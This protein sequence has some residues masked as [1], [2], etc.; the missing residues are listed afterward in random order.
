MTDT[1]P[2]YKDT[3]TDLRSEFDRGRMIQKSIPTMAR[4]E[5]CQFLLFKLQQHFSMQEDVDLVTLFN[6]GVRTGFKT[7]RVPT[8]LVCSPEL[9]QVLRRRS[10]PAVLNFGEIPILAIEVQENRADYLLKKAE[11]ALLEIPEVWMI[12]PEKER[13]QVWTNPTNENGYQHQDYSGDDQ[14]VSTQLSDIELTVAEILNPQSYTEL[15]QEEVDAN[16]E[17]QDGFS[18]EWQQ[19]ALARSEY[20]ELQEQYRELE[21][22]VHNELQEKAVLLELL[23]EKGIDLKAELTPGEFAMLQ[24][25]LEAR[26][27]KQENEELEK[28]EEGDTTL[29]EIMDDDSFDNLLTDEGNELIELQSL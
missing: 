12:D 4:N 13:I 28:A 19:M 1:N 17:L 23:E 21:A 11:Y 27:L 22:L 14:L 29:G 26:K 3:S 15:M 25:D 10:G 16:F 24:D 2:T 18:M 20:E 6:V 8:L 5:I 7:S 9:L